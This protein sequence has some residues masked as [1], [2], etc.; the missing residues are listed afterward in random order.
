MTEADIE[1]LVDQL[2]RQAG[3][4][5]PAVR[6]IPGKGGQANR[7]R[8]QDVLTLGRGI[9]DDT[10]DAR[11][12]AAHEMGHVLL[13]HTQAR[14]AIRTAV[15]YIGSAA[16]AMALGAAASRWWLGIDPLS[17]VMMLMPLWLLIQPGILRR[18]KQPQEREAD[19]YAAAHGAPLTLALAARYT[20]RQTRTDRLTARLFPIHPPWPERAAH[21]ATAPAEG[22][23]ST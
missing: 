20:A 19:T 8:G 18:L 6:W 3:R 12:T 17:G 16:L 15:V 21:A 9:L 4:P 5:S 23:L 10:E 7:R 22:P 1:Q 11:F 13:G 2:A 14:N